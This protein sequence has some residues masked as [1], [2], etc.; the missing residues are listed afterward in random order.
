[1]NTENEQEG[2][3]GK[4]GHILLSNDNFFTTLFDFSFLRDTQKITYFL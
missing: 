1:M 3:K 4:K 2:K